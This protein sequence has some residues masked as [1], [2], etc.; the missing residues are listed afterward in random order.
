MFSRQLF[1]SIALLVGVYF[2]GKSHGFIDPKEPEEIIV[3]SNSDLIENSPSQLAPAGGCPR[4]QGK[5]PSSF[6]GTPP[7]LLISL[8][9]F[10]PDYLKRGISPT[11]NKI[12]QCGSS[13]D[14]MY[15]VFPS[16]TFPNHYSIVT[17][18]NPESHGIVDNNMY[19]PK[20]RKI[21]KMNIPEALNPFWYLKDPIW[22]TALKQ[23]KKTASFYW[24]GSDVKINNVLP[25]YSR[26]Y[27]A[28]TSYNARVDQIL[29]WLELPPA[30]RPSFLTLYVNQ[31][32][33]AG[34]R[35]GPDSKE[36][37]Q[38]VRGVDQMIERLF[39]GLQSKNLL[40]C[41]NVIILS[42]HGMSSTDCKLVVNVENYVNVSNIF[43]TMGPFGRVR[44]KGRRDANVLNSLI[45]KMQCQSQHMRVYP[46]EQLP[47]R[48][49]YADSDRIEP[50]FLDMDSRWT[51]VSRSAKSGDDI[52][53][54][55]A[56]GYDNYYT[57]MRSIFMAH[58]PSIK[59]STKIKP[60]IN[61]ELYEL[62]TEL[63]NIQ[64]EPNN[65]TRGSLHQILKSP[66]KLPIQLEQDPPATG[67]VPRDNQDY[68]FRVDAAEC[69]CK[70]A[71]KQVEIT[72]KDS[73][74]DLHLPFG[75]PY[76]AQD[77][78]TLLMMYNEENIIAFDLKYRLPSWTS[79]NLEKKEEVSKV[80][81]VCFTADARIPNADTAKCSDYDNTVVKRKSIV[82][83]PLYPISFSKSATKE[84]ALY[85]SNSIPKS[86][87]HTNSL[88]TEINRILNRWAAQSG[89]LNVVMGAAFDLSA[90]GLKQSLGKIIRLKEKYGS[91]VVPTH[92]FVIATWCTTSS[93]SLKN[94][95][96][97]K[98][99][100][101]G[102]LLPNDP[103]TQNC[104]SPSAMIEKN[105]ARVVDIENLT[106]LS[107]FTGLPVYDA[108]RLRT[109]MPQ[110]SVS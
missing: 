74:R 97:S 85:V 9:G 36:V 39:A 94:C 101:K 78:R 61:T 88:E 43:S 18:L 108:V 109:G 12:A 26:K 29:Q 33:N 57:D 68:K 90:N 49:H 15:P 42:D 56:H 59:S 23:G 93:D 7:L 83:R 55:G 92:I 30:N 76:S 81:D 48:W 91:L 103:F 2:L 104:E 25:T 80:G 10:R 52:C 106:G 89:S 86:M 19:D 13:A 21:F 32:D 99:D 98:L 6:Q 53:S 45:K 14:F 3:S 37:N 28:K 72:D 5:C 47:V 41:V 24:P 1:Q 50:I 82:Q 46:K 17:G 62:M 22:V 102:F 4:Q 107:F 70:Q 110:R 34:H 65:G 8:D 96:P 77:N 11:L 73:K 67:L 20:T 63:I 79:F 66:K 95:P 60:F 16:K 84:Q 71:R 69:S 54:G 27:V 40:N 64:P 35:N 87:N 58:G 38:A 105:S 44:P 100:S 75:V 51:V 31:P